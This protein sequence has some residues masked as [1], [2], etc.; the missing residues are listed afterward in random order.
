MYQFFVWLHVL[1]AAIWLGGA[2]FLSLVL[3][4][5]VRRPEYRQHASR[6]FQ[7]TG[8]RFRTVGWI[9]L[10]VLAMTGLANLWYR[11]IAWAV[12]ANSGFWAS[13]FGSLL[14]WKLLIVATILALAA[15]HDFLLGP[16]ATAAGQADPGSPAALKLR[17]RASWMGRVNLL[18]ALATVAL[19]V[20]LVRGAY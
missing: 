18:L 20:M 7:L 5:V 9:C 17:R 8:R 19:G 3:V 6:L 15:Y 10:G 4:P 13:P 12:L 11:G 2:V 16:R 1:A 14:G